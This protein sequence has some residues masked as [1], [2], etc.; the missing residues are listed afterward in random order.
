MRS[1]E[2]AKAR[3]EVSIQPIDTGVES[4]QKENMESLNST[5]MLRLP[6]E[7]GEMWKEAEEL[8]VQAMGTSSRVFRTGAHSCR[9]T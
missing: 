5:E 9:S 6:R 8:K 2:E 4:S 1:K 7:R 3:Q